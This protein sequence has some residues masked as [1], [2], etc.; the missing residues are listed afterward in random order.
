MRFSAFYKICLG[1]FVTSFCCISCSSGD[2][3]PVLEPEED[4]IMETPLPADAEP[5]KVYAFR[6]EKKQL[7]SRC[8][9]KFYFGDNPLGLSQK[10]LEVLDKNGKKIFEKTL[11]PPTHPKYEAVDESNY[12]QVYERGHYNDVFA[13]TPAQCELVGSFR[14]LIDTNGDGRNE[15]VV[16][17]WESPHRFY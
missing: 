5:Y 15:S 12:S 7:H 13:L 10:Y 2:A 9:F 16:Q 3:E 6:H 1:M 14:I 11:Y 8:Y 4:I 17:K